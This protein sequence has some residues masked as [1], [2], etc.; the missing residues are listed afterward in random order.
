MYLKSGYNRKVYKVFCCG[1]VM[2]EETPIRYVEA[3]PGSE[4]YDNPKKAITAWNEH[5]RDIARLGLHVQAIN[6]RD[7]GVGADALDAKLSLLV[8]AN[9]RSQDGSPTRMPQHGYDGSDSEMR[10]RDF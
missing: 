3:F 1:F 8:E 9:E 7:G 6:I 5:S 4:D 10:H 2:A